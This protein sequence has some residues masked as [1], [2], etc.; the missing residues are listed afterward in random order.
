MK[1]NP[2]VAE[3]KLTTDELLAKAYKPGKDAMRLHPFYRGK[4]EVIPKCCI[5]N[6]DDFSIWYT[7]GVAEPCMDIHKHPEKVLEHTSK[8]NMV[9][10]VTDGSRVLGLGDIG[11]EAGLPVMEGKAILFKYLGGVDAF[12]LCLKTKDPDEI[13]QAVKWIQPT[14]AGVNLEDIAKPKCFHI[15]N[16]LR[17]EL[18]IPVW[19]DDQQGTAAVTLAGLVNALKVVGKELAEVKITM[20]GAGASNIRICWLLIKAGADPGKIIMVD[21][22]GTLHPGRDDLKDSEKEKWE[23]CQKTNAE[24]RRGGIP[25]AMKKADVLIALSTPGPGVIQKKWVK[26]MAGD[27]I[28]FACANPIPEIWPWEAKAAGARIVATGRSDFPNQVNNSLGFPGIFRGTLDVMASTITDEMCV[29]AAFE[30]AQCAEDKGLNDESI[31]PTMEEWEVYPREAAAV[32]MKA[33]EQGVAKI[34]TTREELFRKASNIIQKARKEIQ[35]LMEEGFIKTP[36]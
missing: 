9:A 31:I 29:A 18:D 28:V 6:F 35:L 19:H 26:S 2:N 22:K 30:L 15:L 34:K 4:I 17:K 21:R 16:T 13:I 8:W 3:K 1:G 24:G 33:I 14:F 11:P 12:P 7:P 10:V 27:A 5:R 36:E 32:G 23:L 25:E 20:V